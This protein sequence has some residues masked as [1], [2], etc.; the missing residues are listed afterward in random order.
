MWSN[1]LTWARQND[2][3]LR[4]R[5]GRHCLE[6]WSN[7]DNGIVIDVSELSRQDRRVLQ[8]RDSWRRAQTRW[9]DRAR[10]RGSR[11]LPDG[12]QRLAWPAR[13]SA[14]ASAF[15]PAASAFLRHLMAARSSSRRVPTGPRRSRRRDAHID[16]LWALRGPETGNSGSSPHSPTRFIHCR[17][18]TYRD[19]NVARLNDLQESSTPGSAR[20]EHRQPPHEP[21]RDPPR[22]ILLFGVL[23]SGS[24]AEANSCWRRSFRLASPMSRQ[25]RE[26]GDTYRDYRYDERRARELNSSRSSSRPV[27]E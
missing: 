23:S 22:A 20:A 11:R 5:S 14:A 12:G 19:R 21:A 2:V 18:V 13:R 4:V 24:E 17:R 6:G 10:A 8:H 7:V 1:A 25:E 16:L 27:P 9:R 15:S 3:A 26:M